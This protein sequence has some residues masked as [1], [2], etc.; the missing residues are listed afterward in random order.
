MNAFATCTDWLYA[1]VGVRFPRLKIALSE[2]GIGW[3]PL[4]LDRLDYLSRFGSAWD[5]PSISVVEVF[6][7]NFWLSS[8]FDPLTY[9]LRDHIGVDRIMFESDYPHF[10][11]SWPNTQDILHSQIRHFTPD[12]IAKVTHQTA[13]ALYRHPF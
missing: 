7:R 4:L 8:F 11:S 2:S 3:V 12:E 9:D 5:E 6:R 13:S 1:K 10:D